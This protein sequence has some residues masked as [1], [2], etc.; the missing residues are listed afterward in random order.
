MLA[1]FLAPEPPPIVVVESDNVVLS[2]SCRVRIPPGTIIPDT[3]ANGVIHV[4]ANDITIEFTPGSVLRGARVGEGGDAVPWDRLTGIGIRVSGQRSVRIVNPSV[5][6]FKV[7]LYADNAPGL[8]IDGGRFADNFRQRLGSTPWAEDSADWLWPHEND[9]REWMTQYGGAIV[10]ERSDNVTVRAVTVRRGQNGIILDRV[11]NSR[12]FDNDC[13]FLSGWGLAMWR[14]SD[15]VIS[16]NAFDFCIRGHSEGIYNRGQDSAGILCFEQCSR[17]FFVEN[18]ATHG[19]DGFFGFAGKEAI[20]EKAPPSP[21]FDHAKAGCNHNEFRGNDFS[22]AAAHGLELTFSS[23]NVIRAGTFTENAICG[24]WGGYSNDFVIVDNHFEGNGGMAYGLE[25]GAINIEHGARNLISANKFINNRTAIHLWWDNDDGIFRLPGMRARYAGPVGNTI[26]GNIFEIN[27]AHP[28]TSPRDTNAK[29]VILRLRD[30]QE[31]GA[32]HLRD[33][34]FASNDIDL[35]YPN[36]ALY[37]VSPGCE[38][39]TQFIKDREEFDLPSIARRPIGDSMPIGARRQLKGRHNIIMGPWGPWD[40][41]EPFVRLLEKGSHRHV[42][43]IRGEGAWKCENLRTGEQSAWAVGPATDKPLVFNVV[44]A[45]DIHPYEYR[46]GTSDWS[47][48]VRGTIV[49]A[50]WDARFFTWG[51]EADPRTNLDAWRALANAPGCEHVAA[52]PNLHFNYAHAGPRNQPWSDGRRDR[53]PGPDYFGMIASTRLRLPKGQWVF[54]TRSDDGVRV[55]INGAPVIENW[56]WHAPTVDRGLY[57]Q[58]EDGEVAIT[59]EHFEIDG[60]AVLEL[61]ITP[62]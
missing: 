2:S 6:G 31:G 14:S 41:H 46:I 28:F 5:E 24:I 62:R 32:G 40:H 19:G 17:N 60:Y 23:H 39:N 44:A 13:S 51:K 50:T 29:L 45:G 38:P 33:T 54:T 27:G 26:I 57:E 11:K 21:D 42:Y 36:A 48:I 55:L 47:T 58:Q 8:I 35:T 34:C 61:D 52:L 9:G 1:C 20:G 10:V 18:S 37:D 25:N 7:G 16:R 53:L 15:N 59:V 49:A 30:T 3:D 4:G 12:I 56:T 22:Y 43:E